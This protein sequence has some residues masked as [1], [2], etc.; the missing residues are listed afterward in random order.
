M[1]E[2]ASIVIP[3]THTFFREV[4]KAIFLFDF[5]KNKLLL[6]WA[7]A[8]AIT[9]HIGGGKMAMGNIIRKKK[10]KRNR[11]CYCTSKKK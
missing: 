4:R 9:L 5:N 2:I 1:K 10:A 7:I 3:F 8:N 6:A 11:N